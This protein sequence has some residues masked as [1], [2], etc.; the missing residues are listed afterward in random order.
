MRVI[1]G[2]LSDEMAAGAVPACAGGD[3]S[4]GERVDGG[5]SE[6]EGEGA[7]RDGTCL[8]TAPSARTIYPE[9][10]LDAQRVK[11]SSVRRLCSALGSCLVPL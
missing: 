1:L 2:Q 7:R 4:A 3:A 8:D 6:A 9:P 5:V 10:V 11:A